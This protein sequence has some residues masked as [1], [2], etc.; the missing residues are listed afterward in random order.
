M[1]PETVL[2]LLRQYADDRAMASYQRQGFDTRR[3]IGVGRTG[4]RAVA[5]QVG[6]NP[7]LAQQLW[8]T[9]V[10]EATDVACLIDDP[11]ALTQAVV[12]ARAQQAWHSTAVQLLCVEVVCCH[13]EA[14]AWALHW[15]QQPHERLQW[16]AYYTVGG[17]AKTHKQLPDAFFLPWLEAIGGQLQQQPNWLR[18][19][20]NMALYYIGMRN[21]ELAAVAL[22][23]A[24]TIGKVEVDYG[25]N[26][27]EALDVAKHLTKKLATAR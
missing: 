16:A 6:R 17:L 19:A 14:P 1:T 15:Q 5:K 13:P 9:G 3:A 26:S 11:K 4:V 7:L 10:Y 22:K 27:C 25:D 18:E 12:E 2:G 24:Q 21:R 23:A 20:M 8:E